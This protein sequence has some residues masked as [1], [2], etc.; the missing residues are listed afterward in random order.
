MIPVAKEQS[1]ATGQQFT[2]HTRGHEAQILVDD[3]NAS[4]GDRPSDGDRP[5]C[6]VLWRNGV[7]AG[8]G[9]VLCRTVAIDQTGVGQALQCL[10]HVRH[11]QHI[12]A[13]Q[14]M[15]QAAQVLDPLVHHEIEKTRREPQRRDAMLADLLT[16]LIERQGLRRWDDESATIQQ[17][18]PDLQGRRI[19]AHRGE[20]QEDLCRRE[21][22][23]V[24][25]PHQ[26]DHR[27]MGDVGPLGL[28]RRA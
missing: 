3:V 18:T 7:A 24:G 15:T 26:A 6:P 12:S 25:P 19:K 11:R 27:P 5:T 13:G 1:I 2:R 16:Q 23:V 28:A 22:Y 17:R 9:R 8:E 10:L 14:Q 21:V 20:L 4:V